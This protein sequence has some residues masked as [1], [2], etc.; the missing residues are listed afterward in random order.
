MRSTMVQ[1][2]ALDGVKINKLTK[3]NS[4]KNDC[5]LL[6]KP[7]SFFQYKNRQT[8]S[9]VLLITMFLVHTLEGNG[10]K[11]EKN[12]TIWHCNS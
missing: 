11:R 10:L 2:N 1:K 8:E 5:S 4:F 9:I 12:Y 6:E 7:V 3:N